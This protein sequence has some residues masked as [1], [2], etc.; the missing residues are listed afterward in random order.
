MR[1]LLVP[2]AVLTCAVTPS[3]MKVR[4]EITRRYSTQTPVSVPNGIEAQLAV[5]AMDVSQAS[6]RTTLLNLAE[7]GQASLI[8]QLGAKAKN[9]SE[10]LA[11]LGKPIKAPAKPDG[12]VDCTVVQRRVILSVENTST[13]PADRISNAR[14]TLDN[15]SGD[16]EFQEW[17]QF[18]TK[19]ETVDLGTLKF[20]QSR[21]FDLDLTVAPSTP[22]QQLGKA[23]ATSKSVNALEENMKLSQRYV[24]VTGS[25]SPQRAVLIQQGVPGID[26][27][28]NLA[29]DL[30]VKVKP[31]SAATTDTF[32]FESIFD[33]AGA[34][35]ATAT[36]SITRRTSRYVPR[37]ASD[38]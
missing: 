13:G 5:F 4:P 37:P 23:E 27:T 24:P 38:I 31:N 28:G 22:A 35:K 36:I 20:N 30:T 26:L 15:L 2:L 6:A 29:V 11:S 7:R 17:T 12:N 16:A 21:E 10:L 8:G 18:A 1:L 9:S 3:C 34:P 19:Y 33:D 25:L 32:D 14:I